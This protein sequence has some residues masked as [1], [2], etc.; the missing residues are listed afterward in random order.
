MTC[1]E[2]RRTNLVSELAPA[3]I[4]I[5]D[6]EPANV[7]LLERLLSQAGYTN[8]RSTTDPRDVRRLYEEFQPDLIL[9]D[10]MM[11]HLD[12]VAVMQQL[13]IPAGEFLPIVILTADVTPQAKERAL[14]AGDGG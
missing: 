13:A 4:L 9:L 14:T 5:A 1:Y 7:R 10:L 3:R 2:I 11:P 12:G 8:I 6:D